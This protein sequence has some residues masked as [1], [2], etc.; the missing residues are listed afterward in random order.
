MVGFTANS[1]A[2]QLQMAKAPRKIRLAAKRKS[3]IV[4]HNDAGGQSRKQLQRSLSKKL[5]R[6]HDIAKRKRKL[7]LLR[8]REKKLDERNKGE[9]KCVT[10]KPAPAAEIG[11]LRNDV[12]LESTSK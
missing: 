4:S 5:Q 11:G 10:T 12:D 6:K 2:S 3:K 8:Q 9:G 7:K 1:P